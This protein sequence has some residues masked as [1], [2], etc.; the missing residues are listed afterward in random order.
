MGHNTLKYKV[1]GKIVKTSTGEEIPE[2]EPVFILRARDRL[3]IRLL[4]HYRTL[5][6]LD[7]CTEYHLNGIKRTIKVFFDF[8]QEHKEKLRQPGSTVGA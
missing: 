1:E 3:A 8:S 7:G 2:D 4:R 6:E 5:C